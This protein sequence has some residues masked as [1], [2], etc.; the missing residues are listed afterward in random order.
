MCRYVFSLIEEI[1]KDWK[2]MKLSGQEEKM[3]KYVK[4][5][6]KFCIC[7]YGLYLCAA[8]SYYPESLISYIIKSTEERTLVLAAIYPFD[9]HPSP[10]FEIVTIV[11]SVQIALLVCADALSEM[12]LGTL[13]CKKE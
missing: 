8:S 5:A 4:Y 3:K 12:F 7:D 1:A 2:N 10:F 6:Y 13:V 11:Q 9:Y